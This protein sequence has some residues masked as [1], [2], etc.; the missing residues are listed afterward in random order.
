[1]KRVS[2]GLVAAGVA[3][4]GA[5]AWLVLR[6]RGAA[7]SSSTP[8]GPKATPA[9]SS[10]SAA[11]AARRAALMPAFRAAAQKHGVPLPWLLA[12]GRK[13]SGF[14]NVRSS[15]GQRD[16]VLGGA[17]GPLQ[18]TSETARAL[19]FAP[20]ATLEARGRAMLADPAQAIELGAKYVARLAG[21]FG[22]DLER[23]AA[24]YN[25]GPGRVRSGKV[26]T[27]TAQKY[28]PQVVAYAREYDGIA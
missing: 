16:D 19:G 24:G 23:V 26:P 1:M 8:A 2:W 27:T 17:W 20:G 15:P 11:Q 22:A 4:A 21:E 12:I 3:G 7:A 10:E 28:V 18:V 5:V 9:S 25:A 14:A 13:E 6:S